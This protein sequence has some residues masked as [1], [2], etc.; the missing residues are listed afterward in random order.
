MNI[1][2]LAVGDV[3]G[4]NGIDFLHDKLR[5]IKKLYN[6]EFTVVNGENAAG[7]GI[8]AAQ[9]EALLD[10]GAD[11]IT[12]G[13]HTW[14]KREIIPFLDDC[15]FILRPSNFAPQTAGRG[16]GVYDTSIGEICVIN[17]IGCAGIDSPYGSEN[18]FR[19]VDAILKQTDS[20]IILVD[21]HAEMTS[22]KYAMAYYLDGRVSAMWGTHTHVQTS[23]CR[24]FKGGTGYITDLGMTGAIESVIGMK[25]DQPIQRF[26][27]NPPGRFDVAGGPV[28]IEG[29]VFEIDADTGR[30][31]SVEAIRVT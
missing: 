28:K 9:A 24:V 27:G 14:N 11:V 25:P 12:L 7:V 19:A 8:T 17:L 13:N 16:W 30:C 2:I 6:I 1:N 26:L 3:A 21:F 22:E 29:A 18:P 20:K 10:A 31:V 15:R 23:D 5:G 4:Q